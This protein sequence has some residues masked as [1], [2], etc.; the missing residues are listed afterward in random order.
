MGNPI[1]TKS[2]N[3]VPTDRAEG[4]P[5]N[6]GVIT[7]RESVEFKSSD[8]DLVSMADTWVKEATPLHNEMLKKQMENEKYYLG[9]QLDYSKLGKYKA[10][11]I[12]NKV[13]QSLE[14]V[15]PRA[16]KRLPAA[17]VSLPP[18]RDESKDIDAN[19]YGEQLERIMLAIA[20]Q[21]KI[22]FKLK[23]FLRFHELHHLGVL[24]FGYD[25][26]EGIWIENVR[27][28]RILVP[29]DMS[30]E[31]V[32]E[33][34]E[35]TV[36]EMKEKFIDPKEEEE[37]Q[38]K[39]KGKKKP[40]KT[41]GDKIAEELAKSNSG[42]PV[43]EGTTVR[44]I[45]VTTPDFKF[46]KMGSVILGKTKNPHWNF[47]DEKK[48][49]WKCKKT[50]YIFSDLWQLGKNKYSQTTLVTQVIS[51]QDSI[52]K[53]KRQISDNADKANGILVA[54]GSGGVTKK[55]VAAMEAAR[56]KPNG[57]VYT[58]DGAQGSVQHFSGQSLQPYVFED[59]QHS[60]NEIDNIFGTHSTTRGEKTPGEETFGGRQLLK[61]SDQE[62]I[63]EL[64]QM[65][66]RIMEEFYN[67][68]AQLIRVHFKKEQ[69]VEYLGA[70]G[71]SVQ[72]K[73]HKN[74]IKEG[75]RINVRQ[76]S[77]LIKDKAALAS[78]AIQL[79]QQKAIDPI[80]LYERL[81]DPNPYRTAERLYLYMTAPDQLFA[82]VKDK[83]E[84]ATK[85]DSEE[86]V[87]MAIARAEMENRLIVQGQNVPPY[88]K[89]NPQHIAVH[90]DFFSTDQFRQ[91][92]QE[93]RNK[94]AAHLEAELQIV[95][96]NTEVQKKSPE[97]QVDL[98]RMIDEK[99]T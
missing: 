13:F 48:N 29:P 26:D 15:I 20:I 21:Q 44:Y 63:D 42:K 60:I 25:E 36:K 73:I 99:A 70:D 51:V 92:P 22:P 6:Q 93:I 9:D 97:G 31:Y 58:K 16:T 78:E 12:L 30:D 53:R 54:Y 85:S 50:D 14:T 52:N 81:G 46:W 76:G 33:M 91:L 37:G 35:S 66:E 23:N 90:Q 11:I 94:A 83:L 57:V 82:G 1:F 4:S 34:H 72:L 95:K 43:P 62:R 75:V 98:N 88:Q 84:K 7:M 5:Q 77:T 24:K 27:A 41:L 86:K 19:E 59:M 18:E 47:E 80:T 68:C 74:L 89:A 32:I 65:L 38:K 64:V 69:Y 71:M 87:L 61:E 79:W 3:T 56:E 2:P 8:S 55:E 49:H 28:Q 45:E 10:K 96:G 67:A 17:M 39:K 40:R